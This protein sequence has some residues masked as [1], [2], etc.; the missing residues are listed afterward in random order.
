MVKPVVASKL[1]VIGNA[2]VNV[3]SQRRRHPNGRARAIP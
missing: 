3:K 1:V 2:V